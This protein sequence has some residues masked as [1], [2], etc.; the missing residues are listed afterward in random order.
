[1]LLSLGKPGGG[2]PMITNSGKKL[3][4]TKEDPMLRFQWGDDLRKT[5]DNSLRYRVS[6]EEQTKYKNE[7]GK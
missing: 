6:K 1:M 2:A 4:K 3:V 5:V 7:L